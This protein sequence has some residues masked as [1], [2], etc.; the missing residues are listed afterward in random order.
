MIEHWLV[1]VGDGI[2]FINSSKYFIWGINSIDKSNTSKFIEEVKEDDILWF[3][4]SKS[5]G[6]AIAVATFNKIKKREIG[7]LVNI[8]LTDDELGWNM[9]D[10]SWDHEIHYKNLYNLSNIDILTKI[11]SP[12]TY[13]KYSDNID[14]INFNLIQEYENIIKYSKI[15][16]SM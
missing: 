5:Q 13:R 7:P 16:N 14:K 4:T 1:R 12:R 8:T 6:K 3:V 9:T 10:G 15:S 2:H 11:K